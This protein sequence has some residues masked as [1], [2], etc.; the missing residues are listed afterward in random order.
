MKQLYRPLNCLSDVAHANASTNRKSSFF[1]NVYK[2]VSL[3]LGILLLIPILSFGKDKKPFFDWSDNDTYWKV[4]YNLDSGSIDL[5]ILFYDDHY[6]GATDNLDG[7]MNSTTLSYSIDG[8][9]FTNFYYLDWDQGDRSVKQSYAMNDANTSIVYNAAVGSLHYLDLKLYLNT[10]LQ[11][12]QKIK[13]SGT[14]GVNNRADENINATKTITIT[15]MSSLNLGYT[16]YTFET[17]PNESGYEGK[18]RI[19]FSKF[20]LNDVDNISVIKLFKNDGT[21]VGDTAIA[22][23]GFYDIPLSNTERTFYFLQSAYDGRVTT[24]SGNV[25]IPAFTLPKTVLASYDTTS[26]KA[27]LSWTIDAVPAGNTFVNDQFKLQLDDNSGFTSPT[28]AS[29]AYSSTQTTFTYILEN[30]FTPTIYFRV[31]RNHTQFEWELAQT[32]HVAITFNAL[33]TAS[34]ALKGKDT[35]RITWVPKASA[36]LPGSVLVIRRTNNTSGSQIEFRITDT[37]VYKSGYY[38]DTQIAICNQYSYALQIEPPQ[39]TGFNAYSAIALTTRI[40]PTQIGTVSNLAVSKGYFPDHTELT[41]SCNGT[42]DR[43]I[44]KRAVYGTESFV[45]LTTVPGATNGDFSVDD[46]KGTPGVYYTY[47]VVGAASCNNQVVYSTDTLYAVGFRSPTGNIYGRV[48]YENGQAVENVAVRLQTNDQ[49]QLGQSVLLSGATNSYLSVPSLKTPFEDSALTVEA[50][51]KPTDALPTNQV[52]FSGGGQYELGFS[53]SGQLYFKYNNGASSVT[54]TY[55]NP[56]HTY[57]HV[58]GIHRKDSMF[59]LLNGLII[60]SAKV[61]WTQS[62][63]ATS[64]YIGST[65]VSSNYKG[66]VDEIRV[67][68]IALSTATVARDY[69]RLLA[70]NEYGLVAYWRLD[71]KMVDQFY[72]ASHRGDQYNQNDGSMNKLQVQRTGVI[73]DAE[74]LGLKDFT[75]ASGNYMI[76]GIPFLGNGTTYTVAPMMGTHTFDPTSAN[77]LVSTASP[78]FNV[79]FKDNSSFSVQG[80]IYY[81]KSTV[82]VQGVQFKIDGQLA[83]QSNGTIIET[84]S[85]GEFTI[86]VP[87]GVH[88]VQAAKNN[89]L[90]QNDGKFID[91][92]GNNRNYQR[93]LSGLQLYDNTTVRFIGRVAGGPVQEALPLGHSVSVNNLGSQ[94]SIVMELPSGTT[95][96][97]DTSS[98]GRRITN[99]HFLPSNQ[100]AT[101]LHKTTVEYNRSQIV[102]HPDTIT[103]EF[104][105]DLIPEQFLAKHVYVTGWDDLLNNIQATI[106]MSNKFAV[107]KS[108]RDYV[109]STLNEQRILVKTNYQDTVFYN[110]A[111]KFIKRIQP[112]VSVD[113]LDVNDNPLAYFGNPNYQTLMFSGDRETVDLINPMGTGRGIYWYNNPVFNQNQLYTFRIKAFESYPFYIDAAK[114][115]KKQNNKDVIDNVPTQ[116]GLVSLYN[117]LRNGAT[118]QPDK[119]SLDSNGIGI[120]QFTAGDPLMVSPWMKD[121]SVSIRFGQA[122]DVNWL[123]YNQ[124]KMSAYIMGGKLTGTDFVTAG[125]D[126]VLFVLRDPPGSKS[127]S[128]A[129]KGSVITSSSKYTGNIKN[130][131]DEDFTTQLGYELITF[132]GIGVGVINRVDTKTGIGF[133]IHHEEHYTGSDTKENTTELTTSFKTSDDPLFVGPPGD[134]FVGYSTNITYGQSNNLTIIKREE[135]KTSDVLIYQ[136]SPSSSHIVVQRIGINIG[137]VFGTL[138]AYPQQHIQNVL[139]PDLI[140]IRNEALLPAGTSTSVAQE[141]ADNSDKIQYVSKLEISN[142]NFGKSNSDTS[143]FHDAAR[144]SA[145][146]DGPSYKIYF[147]VGSYYRTDTILA[148]NQYVDNWTKRMAENE[149]AKLE[150]VLEQNYS[151]H[152]GAPIEH[153]VETAVKTEHEDEFSFVVGAKVTNS[154][155]L[156]IAGSGFEFKFEEAVTTEHGG[157]FVSSTENK[158]KY[159]FTLASE[160]TDDYFSVDVAVAK[161]SAFVFRTKGGSSSCPYSGLNLSKYYQPGTI[162]DQPTV[163][164]EVPVITVDNP[165]ANNVPSARKASFTL[166][167]K[168]ESEAKLAQNYVLSYVNNESIQGATIAVDGLSIANGRTIPIQYGETIPVVLTIERG[169]SAMDYDNIMILWHSGCQ[170]DPTGYRENIADTVLVSA[171]F[172]PSCSD[173]NIKYPNNKWIVNTETPINMQNKRYLH[174]GIDQFDLHNPMF[175]HIELQYKPSSASVWTTA[176]SF[177]PDSAKWWAAQGVKEVIIKPSEIVYD[178]VMDDGT[179]SDQDYDIQA[180]SYCHLGPG[181]DV[182]TLSNLVSGIKDTYPPRLFGSPQPANRILTVNDDVRLNFN[183]TIAAGLLTDAN[184]QVTGIRNGAQSSHSVSVKLDGTTNYLATEFEKSFSG[185]NITAEMW[186][187]PA[188]FANQTIFSHGDASG[189]L[190]LAL[191]SDKKMKVTVGDTVITSATI[192]YSTTDWAHVALIYNDSKK[193]ISTYFNWHPILDG[194]SVRAYT[195]TGHIEFG[196]SIRHQT[197]YFNGK[198]SDARIWNDTLNSLK[199]QVVSQKVLSGTENGLLAYYPMN[200]GKGTVVLDKANGSNAALNGQWS[201]PPSKGVHLNPSGYVKVHT[202]SVPVVSDMDYTLE[203]WFKGDANQGDATLASNGI[204]DGTDPY[205]ASDLFRIGFEGGRLTFLSNG[206]KVQADGNYL[207]NKWHHV[208]VAVNRNSGSGQLSVDGMLNQ[209]FDAQ[210]LGSISS[211]YT[212]LGAMAFKKPNDAVTVYFDKYFTGNIDEFRL[213]NTYLDQNFI[214]K[215]NNVRLN[216]DEL[217]LLAYYPFDAYKMLQGVPTLDYSSKD[218]K[219]NSLDTVILKNAVASDETAPIKDRGPV[220]NLLFDFVVN[221]DALII[222]LQEPKADIQKSVITFKAERIRDLNGNEMISPVTWTA[223]IDQNLVKWSDKEINLVKMLG[224]PLTF[225]SYIVNN[226]GNSQ[227]FTISNLPSWLTAAPSSGSVDPNSNQKIVFTVDSGLN[228]GS[229]EELITMHNDNNETEVLKLTLKVKGKQPDWVVKPSDYL[230]NMVVY[231][232]L[233]LNNI[234]STNTDDMLGAFLNG[235]CIGV[236]NNSNTNNEWYAFLTMYSNDVSNTNIEFRLWEAKTGKIYIAVTTPISPINFTNNAIVGSVAS[237]INFDAGPTSYRNIVLNQNWNWISFNLAIPNNTPLNTTLQDGNWIMDDVIKNEPAS[238]FA[239][240]TITNAAGWTGTLKTL[241]NLTAYKLKVSTAQSLPVNGMAV[242]VT[243]KSITLKGNPTWSYISYLPPFNATLKDALAG[244]TAASDGDV[245]KSQTGFAMYSYSAKAWIGSLTYMEPGKGYMVYRKR[246]GDTTFKYPIITGSLL[247]GRVIEG[248]AAT[249]E[250]RPVPANFTHAD[251]MT[252]IAIVAPGFDLKAGDTIIAYVNGE[253]R[254]KAKPILNPEINKY[255]WFFTIGG[256]AEQAIAFIVER[257]GSVVAQS[258]T[259]VNYGSNK[260]VGTLSKPLELQ[261]VKLADLIT[262]NPNPF[263]QQTTINVDLSRLTGSNAQVIQLSVFDVSGRTVWGM[264]LKKISGLKYTATWNGKN[265]A[266]AVCSSGV[267]IVQVAINGV[268]YSY[269]LIKQ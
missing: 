119:L 2:I 17:M 166:Y 174:I 64:V 224:D 122:T 118:D 242:D 29:V 244:Y 249:A 49:M 266:G 100:P 199:L 157:S 205:N 112:S 142:A 135:R 227:H 80:H 102:I 106:D 234:Y 5:H 148:L 41:W 48:T 50:W 176:V 155:E 26:H 198:M 43:F 78:V 61:S 104:V 1:N 151:F 6:A 257:G 225:S 267:Y 27:T 269:K 159:G 95:Y 114:N 197:S 146:G 236:T 84:N 11:Q 207:D 9:S 261:F 10:N 228:I 193:T 185:K 256:D 63:P 219:L 223:Y 4:A 21:Y 179:F 216:G 190:E 19:Y 90:F 138:F 186:V 245:I 254:G 107:Q 120:Y 31:A 145:F 265:H 161:D 184:F 92:Q 62:S 201:T 59:L 101:N 168:N 67:W 68:N 206:F 214:S 86:S 217:G 131:G 23:N 232:R 51:I 45:Q 105:A 211:A 121:F 52:L 125:P 46:S 56:N 218:G 241:D 66:Y 69:T 20:S 243:K 12:I 16:N 229:Y 117:N 262:V 169:P 58:A 253:V 143:A 22:M 210:Y 173:I 141:L 71:E 196:R 110:V 91:D 181:N 124:P 150:A 180:V 97:L 158:V 144:N 215:Y 222:N 40:L 99:D 258:T 137:E 252:V 208:A 60:G 192:N 164:G 81:D 39:N 177:Y 226:G 221:N 209:F 189:S 247:G 162:I 191:T 255:T 153:S 54:G 128:M 89:H 116:D 93:A 194:V 233:R 73:P 130:E 44:V 42:F 75:D 165:V 8:A 183:E 7:W 13:I 98:A 109:D 18:A 77:R 57:V 70:G 88:E 87:V 238:T 96:L 132:T 37:T 195:G 34:V 175:D 182:T 170:Y 133:G 263:D 3:L 259:V 204:G 79:D 152:S 24:A 72:D 14:W 163:R 202:A 260:V 36:W 160:G 188:A 136:S 32:T 108:I 178:L 38:D 15:K 103:G 55:T 83:Q 111:Y 139:I 28:Q 172:I 187:L 127:F 239:N 212:Y 220:E 134:V 200:E 30:N 76:T 251:N 147:P 25:T 113:Q 235:K 74:F 237:P 264:P 231:G 35:A 82:P 250:Q 126:K 268:P 85:T 53:G 123:W 33:Q 154:S 240:Y 248:P 203:M 213:W 167:L 140:K 115:I 156:N 47:M 65:G 230:Y 149:K 94:L 171:H 246:T 129:E